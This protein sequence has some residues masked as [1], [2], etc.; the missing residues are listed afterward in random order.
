MSRSGHGISQLA[1]NLASASA[2]AASSI[3]HTSGSAS[4]SLCRGM[5]SNLSSSN[6][7]RYDE[8]SGGRHKSSSLAG[9]T[10]G[11]NGT[12]TTAVKPSNSNG[13]TANGS[14]TTYSNGSSLTGTGLSSTTSTLPS[15]TA[16]PA[17][18]SSNAGNYR[19]A[20]LDRLAMRQ[21]LYDNGTGGDSS[22][23]PT[24]ICLFKVEILRLA[25][26]GDSSLK[27]F[28]EYCKYKWK[29]IAIG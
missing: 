20:S 29:V 11:S 18:Y 24:S 21:K 5:D 4:S 2:A 15:G 26:S 25:D 16:L 9:Y 6:K 17:S 22:V 3:L 14:A 7:A 13:T 19:L 12:A 8:A 10:S 27:W 28:G 1:Q 23:S